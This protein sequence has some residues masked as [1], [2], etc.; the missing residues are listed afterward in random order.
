ML[1]NWRLPDGRSEG[2]CRI[3]S[4]CALGHTCG[5][6]GLAWRSSGRS[7]TFGLVLSQQPGT[8]AR[9][10]GSQSG[11]PVDQYGSLRIP[12]RPGRFYRYSGWAF[13]SLGT[14]SLRKSFSRVFRK[15]ISRS[16]QTRWRPKPKQLGPASTSRAARCSGSGRGCRVPAGESVPF[17]FRGVLRR[18]QCP[19]P[20]RSHRGSRPR[21]VEL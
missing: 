7:R 11:F 15:R 17:P 13:F 20:V 4:R 19:C 9:Q 18:P 14:V 2:H 21:C 1:G 10:R 12:H 6:T 3:R 8:S 16:T 5:R